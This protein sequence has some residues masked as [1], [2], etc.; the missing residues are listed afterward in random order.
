PAAVVSL[1]YDHP[2][3]IA[4]AC[5]A[6]DKIHDPAAVIGNVYVSE[7]AARRFFDSQAIRLGPVRQTQAGFITDWKH[8]QRSRT[9]A[10]RVGTY[11]DLYR[12]INLSIK[13]AV[14]AFRGVDDFVV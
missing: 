10:T 1:I 14:D 8:G 5:Q 11:G 7:L 2:R 6:P 3:S 13:V 9:I 4:V 12:L